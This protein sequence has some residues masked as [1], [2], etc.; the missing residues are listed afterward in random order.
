M[1]WYCK[2]GIFKGDYVVEKY[3]TLDKT[4]KGN[5]RYHVTDSQD[6]KKIL[7]VIGLLGKW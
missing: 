1:L 5:N 4:L 7:S 3:Y 2:N 6:T